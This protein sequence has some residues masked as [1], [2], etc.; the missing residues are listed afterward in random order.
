MEQKQFYS[1]SEAAEILGCHED[2]VRN[3]DRRGV[4]HPQRNS[5]G[6]RF[7]TDED[8]QKIRELMEPAVHV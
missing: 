5:Y 4:I 8:I 1:V 3:Y 6:K 2:T 7:L